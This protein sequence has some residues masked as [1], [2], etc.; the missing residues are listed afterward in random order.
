MECDHHRQEVTRKKLCAEKN[1][2]LE[3]RR[4]FGIRLTPPP[5]QSRAFS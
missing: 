2:F 3:A 1:V 4:M 5:S